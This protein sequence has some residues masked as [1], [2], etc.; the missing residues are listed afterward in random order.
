MHV[1]SGAVNLGLFKVS[2]KRYSF[3][4][5]CVGWSERFTDFDVDK[6]ERVTE[7]RS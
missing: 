6:V 1:D 4:K 3:R 7:A 2:E 5:V